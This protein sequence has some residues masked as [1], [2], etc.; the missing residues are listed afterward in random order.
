MHII[1]TPG[2]R[3]SALI[4][5]SEQIAWAASWRVIEVRRG[6]GVAEAWVALEQLRAAA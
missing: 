5:Y 2:Q 1:G 3:T 4:G 6:A